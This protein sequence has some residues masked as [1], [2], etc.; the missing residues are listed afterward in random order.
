[1]YK[2]LYSKTPFI[3]RIIYIYKCSLVSIND[4]GIDRTL[5]PEDSGINK[6]QHILEEDTNS[7]A[8]KEGPDFIVRS[9][10]RRSKQET[11]GLWNSCREW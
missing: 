5:E 3:A 1:M 9:T 8:Q 11:T 7:N 6:T 2:E 10:I 4:R